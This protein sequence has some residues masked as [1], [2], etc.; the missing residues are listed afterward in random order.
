[1]W[2]C[3]IKVGG[4]G[5]LGRG[6]SNLLYTVASHCLKLVKDSTTRVK[7]GVLF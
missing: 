5:G 2:E 7:H 4:G 3:S 1:V 6:G